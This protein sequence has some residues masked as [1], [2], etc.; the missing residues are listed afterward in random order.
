MTEYHSL[1]PQLAI[2]VRKLRVVPFELRI[3]LLEELQRG[4]NEGMVQGEGSGSSREAAARNF[5]GEEIT[6]GMRVKRY[7]RTFR[8]Y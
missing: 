1:F 4:F 8:L 5:S 7:W 2:Q 6:A 3:A